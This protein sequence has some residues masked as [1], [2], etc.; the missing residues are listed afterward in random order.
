MRLEMV[1]A[2][3]PAR[4]AVQVFFFVQMVASLALLTIGLI[5]SFVFSSAGDTPLYQTMLW[6]ILPGLAGY[7]GPRVWLRSKQDKRRD[8]I[9]GGFP[10]ALDMLLVCVEAGQSLDQSIA[11]VALELQVGHPTL[12]EEF[13]MVSYEIRAGKGKDQVLK[14]MAERVDVPEIHSFVTVLIQSQNFGTSVA[15]ALRMYASEMRDKRVQRAEEKANTMPTKMS[16]AT[17]LLT[18]PP[19]LLILIGPSIYRVYQSLVQGAF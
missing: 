4:S 19:V 10:D 12:A 16:L 1:R 18:T 7:L 6:V 13:E 14:E 9:A 8:E 11:R 17:M 3:Y 15:D 5:A 2:G